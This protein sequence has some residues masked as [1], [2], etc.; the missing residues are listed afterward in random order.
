[1]II[2]SLFLLMFALVSNIVIQYMKIKH[3]ENLNYLVN[4][5]V[6]THL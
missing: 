1:M 2:L 6:A 5:L 4:M 3:C